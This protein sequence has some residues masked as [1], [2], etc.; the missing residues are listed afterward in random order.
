MSSS[1]QPTRQAILL[2]MLSLSTVGISSPVNAQ[3]LGRLFLSPDERRLIDIHPERADTASAGNLSN[4]NESDLITVNGLV[5]RSSGKQTIWLNKMPLRE[6]QSAPVG[7][8]VGIPKHGTVELA[9]PGQSG[10]QRIKPGQ[11]YDP[12][13]GTVSERFTKAPSP[14]EP[15]SKASTTTPSARAKE[16]NPTDYLPKVPGQPQSPR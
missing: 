16:L 8:P 5:T 15:P 13:S 6:G 9:L 10:T 12:S 3:A 2:A 11:S 14:A 1:Y 7:R 4:K